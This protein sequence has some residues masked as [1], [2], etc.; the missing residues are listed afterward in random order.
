MSLDA[1]FERWLAEENVSRDTSAIDVVNCDG[2]DSRHQQ[3]QQKVVAKRDI[4]RGEK[5]VQIPFSACFACDERSL[6]LC[7]RK[8]WSEMKRV[9]EEKTDWLSR[10]AIA[11]CFE[12]F[13][14]STTSWGKQLQLEEE[15]RSR[16]EP[17]LNTLNERELHAMCNWEA[18]EKDLLLRGTDIGLNYVR[19][20][21]E[22]A[23]EEYEMFR[24]ALPPDDEG[25]AEFFTFER[26]R[27]SRSVCSSRA[28][29][30]T[31]DK[32]GLMPLAD[33][34]NH[35]STGN[36]V[37]VCE[38]DAAETVAVSVVKSATQKG[39]EVFNTYGVLSNT[40]LLN[41]YGFCDDTALG[42]A[43][44]APRI[45]GLSVRQRFLMMARTSG[46][47]SLPDAFREDEDTHTIE[48]ITR[49]L[50]PRREDI[51]RSI[52]LHRLKMY[53]NDKEF[54]RACETYLLSRD[55]VGGGG[56]TD[57]QERELL[58]KERVELARICRRS[59]M[60]CLERAI[61]K[62]ASK[63]ILAQDQ[64]DDAMFSVFT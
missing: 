27:A 3:Q 33:L 37:S 14:I 29:Q 58:K 22:A 38:G 31:P 64:E 18:G 51:L 25:F 7:G 10:L 63:S 17:Y 15:E 50:P 53:P 19:D 46:I 16:F 11:L 6:L 36:D 44:T 55:I 12:R 9:L 43:S 39:E 57:T 34:F 52:L 61:E 60:N 20:E 41:S 56:D 4:V 28:F 23:R 35:K 42:L 40:D 49:L 30:I 48:E 21:R 62:L 13:C 59:E 5:L 1:S 47:N 26:Y 2:F 8:K 24:A 32:I 45:T 54:E